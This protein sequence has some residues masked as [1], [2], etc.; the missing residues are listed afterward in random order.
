[1]SECCEIYIFFSFSFLFGK[2]SEGTEL[3]AKVDREEKEG[4][5]SRKGRKGVGS[6]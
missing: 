3:L 6:G 5:G 4:L 2:E 1:M